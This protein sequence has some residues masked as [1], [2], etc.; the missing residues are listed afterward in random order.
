MRPCHPSP[1]HSPGIRP[2]PDRSH[3]VE[4]RNRTLQPY[5]ADVEPSQVRRYF[6]FLK[7]LWWLPVSSLLFS[8]AVAASYLCWWP[9][10]YVAVAHMWAAGRVGLQLHEGT[11][12]SEDVQN[13]DGTQVELLQ[14]D[15]ILRRA[16]RRVET[17]LGSAVPTTAGMPAPVKIR[18]CQIPK[19]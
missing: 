12:Y 15:E 10:S 2:R 17:T 8:G 9:A 4:G 16:L 3:P 14:S 7:K 11:T 18:V 1:P 6:T 5:P 19:S 13:F